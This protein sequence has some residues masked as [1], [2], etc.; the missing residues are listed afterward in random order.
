MAPSNAGK[1][2][3][4]LRILQLLRAE[5]TLTRQ[6]IAQKLSLSMPTTLQNTNEL[7]ECGLLE[8]CGVMESTGGRRA[9]K[10]ALN[11]NAGLGL[12]IDIE[13][14]HIELVITNLCGKV[15]VRDAFPLTFRDES[16][17]YQQFQQRIVDFLCV[18][19]IDEENIIGAGLCFPGIV[20][21]ASGMIV[22]SHIFHL[23]HVSLDR[24][25]KCI[26]FPM[27]AANDANCACYAELTAARPTYLYLSLNE[28]VGGALMLDGK[29]HYGDSWQAGEVGHMLL[30]PD[31]KQCYCGKHGCADPYLSPKA[32]LKEGQSLGEFFALIEAGNAEANV[33][34]DAYLEHLAILLTNLRMLCNVDIMIGGAVGTKIKPYMQTLNAKAAKYDLF[35]RDV[36]YIYPCKRKTHAFAVGAAMLA[37]ERYG[38]RLLEDEMLTKLRN[39]S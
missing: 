21:D 38:S 30:I 26:P 35:A 19:E 7:L 27:I 11:E 32:L 8:E 4:Q 12:G 39:K 34:W 37:M 36:D 1:K 29:L 22:R 9:K 14:H 10:L 28:S 5:G 23:E 16:E 25:K 13:L 17:W 3:T 15:M 33:V 20:D 24:F 2:Q 6:D 31:G 18:H